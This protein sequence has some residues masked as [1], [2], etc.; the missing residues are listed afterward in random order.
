MTEDESVAEFFRWLCWGCV[1]G[2]SFHLFCVLPFL[3]SYF[4]ISLPYSIYFFSYFMLQYYLC[5][6]LIFLVN[7]CFL[8]FVAELLVFQSF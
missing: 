8:I 3:G 1:S 6:M 2:L 4:K 7:L 5:I